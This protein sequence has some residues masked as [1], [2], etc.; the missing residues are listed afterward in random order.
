MPLHELIHTNV[1]FIEI[2]VRLLLQ[3]NIFTKEEFDE[4]LGKQVFMGAEVSA[5]DLVQTDTV[6]LEVLNRCFKSEGLISEQEFRDEGNVI[7]SSDKT[8]RWNKRTS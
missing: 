5:I 8:G 6:R 4:T 2:L 7:I 1:L 3:K